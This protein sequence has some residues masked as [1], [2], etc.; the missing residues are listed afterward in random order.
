MAQE[1]KNLIRLANTDIMGD[2][3]IGYGLAKVYGVGLSFSNAICQ[4]LD[5]EKTAPIGSL[6]EARVKEIE[7]VIADPASKG[8][9]EWM[10]NRR[11]DHDT[12]EDIHITGP[13]LKLTKEFD[14]RR[15]KKIKSYRGVRHM[16][17]LP[18][19]GQRTKGNFRK[20]KSVGV[21]KKKK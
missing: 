2:T 10:R 13:K 12:G 7:G 21:V 19:R 16:F 6:D 11:S 14:L 15:M 17:G 18:V 3:T 4:V 5:L 1:I 20:G 8:I 9:P